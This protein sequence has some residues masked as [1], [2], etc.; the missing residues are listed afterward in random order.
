MTRAPFVLARPTRRSRGRRSLTTRRSAGASS[1]RAMQERY[2]TTRWGRRPRT[3][4][5]G[6]R[7][8]APTRTRSRCAR[9]ERAAAALATAASRSRSC[10]STLARRRRTGRVVVDADEHPRADTTLEKLATL[11]PVVR[12]TARS[13]PA[14]P[15]ASTTARPPCSSP[16]RRRREH[17]L[18]PRARVGAGAVAGVPPRIMGIGPVP[19]ARKLLARAGLDVGDIDV[20][21]LNEAFAAQA[22]ACL[23]EL[24]LPDARARQPERRR[25]RARPPA[26]LPAARG[27]R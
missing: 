1:T 16:P 9:Q 7:S 6:S 14:T 26:G 22:L 17:G 2:G 23:R 18:T 10:R 20:V 13:R 19:A 15:R 3:S 27:S 24:G 25:D 11:K 21:E 8:R 5:S 4:R 12:P